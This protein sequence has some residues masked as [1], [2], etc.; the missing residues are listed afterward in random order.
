MYIIHH[1]INSAASN[2]CGPM[3]SIEDSQSKATVEWIKS[4]LSFKFWDKPVR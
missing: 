2:S 4:G 1:T 3:T